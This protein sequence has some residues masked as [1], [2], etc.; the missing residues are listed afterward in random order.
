MNYI[1]S[2]ENNSNTNKVRSIYTEGYSFGYRYNVN[3]PFIN[4][5]YRRY[6][7][8]K[9][10]PEASPMSNEERHEFE[11]YLDDFFA[12]QKQEQQKE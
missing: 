2:K 7:K 9:N 10:I 5:L 6:K 11:K 12:K 1:N 3:H 8:W 4:D